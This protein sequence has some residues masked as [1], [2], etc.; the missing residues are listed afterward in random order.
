MPSGPVEIM[1]EDKSPVGV[2][3]NNSIEIPWRNFQEDVSRR[4]G[5]GISGSW[6]GVQGF[7]GFRV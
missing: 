4:R 3:L 1:Q 2:P 5:K 7:L 6:D